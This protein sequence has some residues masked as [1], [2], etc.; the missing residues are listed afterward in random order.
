MKINW[1]ILRQIRERKQKENK[2]E[3]YSAEKVAYLLGYYSV[4]VYKNLESW[5]QKWMVEK[6]WQKLKVLLKL[7]EEEIDLLT[8][9]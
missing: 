1:K 3:D 7:T 2:I 4:Q 5:N 6:K 9:V 8:S